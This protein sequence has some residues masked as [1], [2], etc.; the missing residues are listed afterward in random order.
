MR[1]KG[2]IIIGCGHGKSDSLLVRQSILEAGISSKVVVVDSMDRN[3]MKE[4][5]AELV[6]MRAKE[7]EQRL[8]I[9]SNIHYI[10]D[11]PISL[12][13]KR[14]SQQGWKKKHKLR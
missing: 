1:K 5:S 13:G 7:T 3:K 12:N 6:S 8:S 11:N 4:L 14:Q 10:A 2:I 9:E